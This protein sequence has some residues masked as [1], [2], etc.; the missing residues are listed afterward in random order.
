MAR[1]AVLRILGAILIAAAICGCNSNTEPLPTSESQPQASYA[2]NND[3]DGLPAINLIDQHGATVSL[4]TLKGRPVL[5]DFIYASCATACPV[6]TAR[7]TR[8]ADMLGGELG[9]RVTMVS[10]TLDPEHDHPA[11]LL[12]YAR[13]HGADRSG[14]LLLTGEPGAIDTLLGLYRVRREREPDGSIA[15][16][17]TSF[18]LGPDGRQ[19]REYDTMKVAPETV[20]ADINRALAGG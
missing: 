4:A 13:T 19:L 10:I 6:M 15:H 17:T 20:T 16:V 11:Q 12:E 18:L 9:S 2:P 1:A 3:A 7:F 8:I 14:W 5:L